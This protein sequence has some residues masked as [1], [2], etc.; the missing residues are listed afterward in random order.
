MSEILDILG[1]EVE[2]TEKFLIRVE[3]NQR[4]A[5]ITPRQEQSKDGLLTHR[6]K[7]R[8][9]HKIMVGLDFYTHKHKIAKKLNR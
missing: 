2:S 7:Y 5:Q 4:D 1:R 6:E 8:S 9:K 3:E